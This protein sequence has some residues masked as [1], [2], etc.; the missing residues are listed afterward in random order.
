M[1]D[2]FDPYPAF[3][4]LTHLTFAIVGQSKDRQVASAPGS[5][6]FVAPYVAVT[7]RHVVEA[8]WQELNL[9]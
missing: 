7:A 6:F 2:E 5:G 9:P 3:D 4:L 8:L 1:P